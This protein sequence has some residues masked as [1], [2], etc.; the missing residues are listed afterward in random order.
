MNT[1]LY[2]VLIIS[3]L[4]CSN[5]KVRSIAEANT[6]SLSNQN[7]IFGGQEAS[8]AFQQQ[9]GIVKIII[10][11]FDEE[12]AICTGTLISAKLVLTAAHCVNDESVKSIEVYFS[13]SEKSQ[14]LY[15]DVQVHPNNSESDLAVIQI[16][17]AAPKRFQMARLPSKNRAFEI[18]VNTPVTLAG[19]GQSTLKDEEMENDDKLRFVKHLPVMQID[20]GTFK[21]EQTTK[22]ACHGDSGGPA[23]IEMP[24]GS[25][26]QIGVIS[27]VLD[28]NGRCN[29]QL[30]VE[31]LNDSKN[32]N[33]LSTF[34][35]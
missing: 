32:I 8:A 4:S 19:Y 34:S 7:L 18:G 2:L 21:I 13:S 25:L 28:S 15:E 14:A 29:S 31:N 11:R 1:I 26:F 17:K 35:N 30:V 24:N 5:L 9:Y 6:D 3:L 22:G 12:E 33:W 23:L 16:K 10:Q 20:K 27:H